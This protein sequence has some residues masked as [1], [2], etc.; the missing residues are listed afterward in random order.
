MTNKKNILFCF[1][2]TAYFFPINTIHCQ[3]QLNIQSTR[4][5]F[6]STDERPT[7][8]YVFGQDSTVEALK[9]ELVS[10]TNRAENFILLASNVETIAA[11]KDKEQRYILYSRIYF[12]AISQTEKAVL[13]AHAIGHHAL[14]HSFEDD[15]K[16]DED[17]ETDEYMGFILNLSGYG[18]DDI[19]QSISKLPLLDTNI[20]LRKMTITSGFKRGETLLKNSQHAAF[21]EKEVSEVLKNMPVFAL[22]PPIPSA[23]FNLAGYFPKC[24]TVG[25]VDK[26]ILDALNITGY[27]SKKYYYTEGGYALVTKM[28]QFNQDGSSKQGNA[29]WAAKPVRNE[30]FSIA[31]YLKALFM[32]EAGFFRV[33]VFVVSP[34]Y[35]GNN[36]GVTNNKEGIMGWLDNGYTS[37]PSIIGNRK[38]TEDT[39]IHALIYEFKVPDTNKKF[40]FSKPSE[41][42]GTTHLRMAKILDNLKK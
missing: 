37:L 5:C 25:Q 18:L 39:Q 36:S 34:H 41:L 16:T 3:E 22:P 29:R 27:Y 15:F 7:E 33:L 6:Y 24:R 8:L 1:F 40:T 38:L 20:D 31:N 13:L 35:Y 4:A 12:N 9:N 19:I 21:S 2:I 32:P 26:S 17:V 23:E 14:K 30:D 10:A 28:E 42:D 11:I